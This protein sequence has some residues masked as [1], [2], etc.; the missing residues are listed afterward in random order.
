MI[1]SKLY[2][3]ST[4][5]TSCI[6]LVFLVLLGEKTEKWI[7]VSETLIM[8]SIG[9]LIFAFLSGQPL[10]IIGVTGPTLVFEESL[11]QVK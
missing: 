11:Y 9:G 1:S 7:G 3:E 4:C 8:T 5:N 6:V 10:V 2:I